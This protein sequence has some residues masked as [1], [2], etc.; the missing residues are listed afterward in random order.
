MIRRQPENAVVSSAGP[1]WDTVSQNR[2][3]SYSSFASGEVESI[4]DEFHEDWGLG[5]SCEK[6]REGISQADCED[7]G[8]CGGWIFD[9]WWDD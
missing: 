9:F 5:G 7:H 8:G 3:R 1:S 6:F 2:A 4:S